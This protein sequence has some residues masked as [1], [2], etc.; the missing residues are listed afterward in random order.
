MYLSLLSYGLEKKTNPI[1]KWLNLFLVCINFVF[2]F[3]RTINVCARRRENEW[4]F[5]IINNVLTGSSLIT[6]VTSPTVW[7]SERTITDSKTSRD[8]RRFNHRVRT[9]IQ[10]TSL[11]VT[12]TTPRR[13]DGRWNWNKRAKIKGEDHHADHVFRQ[14]GAFRSHGERR[15]LRGGFCVNSVMIKVMITNIH[16]SVFP[17]TPIFDSVFGTPVLLSGSCCC[18]FFSFVFPRLKTILKG[19]HGLRTCRKDSC[20]SLFWTRFEKKDVSVSQSRSYTKVVKSALCQCKVTC[21][22][23][24]WFSCFHQKPFLELFKRILRIVNTSF[25][26]HA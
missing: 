14:W 1:R 11:G 5:K 20:D 12:G 19:T 13:K 18:W 23:R 10:E 25:F 17:C 21:S 24:C 4:R 22:N 6:F 7:S 3:G 16:K 8:Q 26:G 9:R 15:I 2:R